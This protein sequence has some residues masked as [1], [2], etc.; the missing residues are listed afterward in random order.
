[1]TDIY[2]SS[3]FVLFA[4]EKEAEREEV[5][6]EA[7]NREIESIEK[8]QTWKLVDLPK[9]KDAVG[10]KWIFKIKFNEDGSILKHKARVVAKGY[11]Q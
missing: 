10:L 4:G 6:R 5:W 8:N 3:N 1:M 2:A 11:S 9:G 7:M